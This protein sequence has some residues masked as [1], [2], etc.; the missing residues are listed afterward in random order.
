EIWRQ[1]PGRMGGVMAQLTKRLTQQ[2]LGGFARL[3]VLCFDGEEVPPV[4]IEKVGDFHTI[5]SNDLYWQ[6]ELVTAAGRA[7]TLHLQ[8]LAQLDQIGLKVRAFCGL[9]A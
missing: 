4:T 7:R 8:R 1:A 3:L 5:A 9:G 6:L 2:N